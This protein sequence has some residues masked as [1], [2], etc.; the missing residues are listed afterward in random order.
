[1]N[2]KTIYLAGGCFWGAEHFFQ[3]I[4]GI[5][6]TRTGFANGNTENPTYKEVYTDTTGFAETVKIDYD[7]DRMPL[8]KLLNL[9]F[10]IIDPTSLNKQGEDEGTRYR[11]GIYYTDPSEL[12]TIKNVYAE[13]EAKAGQ[14]LVVEV[15][16]LR[17]W[18]SA[19]DYHQDYLN[20]N[21]TGYCHLP[22]KTFVYAK[23]LSE[24]ELLLGDE[25]D[26]IARMSNTAAM[27]HGRMHFWW[28]GFY[29]VKPVVSGEGEELV[30]GPF[31][32]PEA[33]F[34]IKKG[35]GVCGTAWA[36]NETVVVPDVEEFPGHIA[37]SSLS[38]SE[39]VVPVYDKDGNFAAELDIDSKE[40]GTFDKTDQDWLEMIVRLI[41][42]K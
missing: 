14:P 36:R 28:T 42:I 27:V 38:R 34:R 29:I 8:E 39:I 17:N 11:T 20:R 4:G 25:P 18:Y 32:G 21:P 12:D 26:V 2:K 33:C 10:M 35:R 6:G 3:Q 16:E 15:E 40:I 13:Q 19:E 37:C 23:L 1:M 31:Q 5:V 22:L 24:L 7:A 41:Y 30:L 9:F